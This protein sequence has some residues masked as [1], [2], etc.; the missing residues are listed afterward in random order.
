VSL[1]S[2]SGDSV[3]FQFDG[4]DPQRA[5]LLKHLIDQG[6]EILEFSGKTESLEDAFMA[7]TEGIMQ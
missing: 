7:I 2:V 6:A 4:D 5:R 1:V 3:S